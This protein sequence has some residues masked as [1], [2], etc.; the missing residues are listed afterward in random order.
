MGAQTR[1]VVRAKSGGV[2]VHDDS[3][4]L[5]A[6]NVG[7]QAVAAVRFREGMESEATPQ[8]RL[9]RLR[10]GLEAGRERR[11]FFSPQTR[12]RVRIHPSRLCTAQR[13]LGAVVGLD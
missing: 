5:A 13:V 2:H 9:A 4:M 3:I 6:R 1:P 10:A 12:E 7:A 8:H 11:V